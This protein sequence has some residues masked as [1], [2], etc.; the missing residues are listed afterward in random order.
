MGLAFTGGSALV[1]TKDRNDLLVRLDE[2]TANIWRLVEKIEAHQVSQN[3][4]IEKATALSRRNG[5]WI[6]VLR[7][8]GGGLLLLII[9]GLTLI[10]AHIVG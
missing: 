7:Y 3:G 4:L 5:I 10:V 1:K 6:N 8:G 2:K 9:T